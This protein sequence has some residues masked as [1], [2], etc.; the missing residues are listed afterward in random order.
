MKGRLTVKNGKYYVVISYKD[1]NGNNKNKWVATGLDEK[2]NKRAAN[3]MLRTIETQFANGT[4][5]VRNKP[6]VNSGSQQIQQESM[7]TENSPLFSDYLY[8]WLQIAKSNIQITT[9]SNYKRRVKRIADY[10][11]EKQIRLCDLKPKDIQDFYTYLLQNGKSVQECHHCHTVLHRALEVAYRSDYILTNPAD[12]V[13]RPKSPKY[14]AKFY[15]AEQMM[16]FFEKLAGDPYEYIYKLAAIYGM[17]RSEVGGLRWS[18]INFDNNTVTLDHAVV[19]C[20]VEGKRVVIAKD[21]MKNQ[22]SMRTLPLLPF[23]KDMLLNLKQSQNERAAKYGQYYNQQY[24]DYVC[25]DEVGK[26]IRPDTLTTHFKAFLV[27]NNLPVIRLH[28]LR[29]SCASI[30]IASRVSMKAV[31]EWL[32]HSTYS[33]TADI[34]SHLNFS[35]KLGIADTLSNII[36]GKPIVQAQT[37]TNSMDAMQKIFASSEIAKPIN[38]PILPAMEIENWDKEPEMKIFDED[39][40]IA[41][42]APTASEDSFAIFQNAKEEM[43]LFGLENLDE[44]FEYLDFQERLQK[45]RETSKDMEM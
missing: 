9:Y 11:R 43:Q 27:R 3:D 18:A 31:Q 35:S 22:S 2:N 32:G 16:T 40:K 4:L 13:E 8:K 12:K 10:F 44:Y 17:R 25:V 21:K 24:R 28:E 45:R 42:N 38:H 20:E 37:S 33:T 41:T 5:G 15:T 36:A 39:N 1:E 23:V 19:Q 34:Y 14:K 7:P 26:L 6:Q 30:L 29:H